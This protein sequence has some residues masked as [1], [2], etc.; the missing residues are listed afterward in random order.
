MVWNVNLRRG[1]SI[2][3][4]GVGGIALEHTARRRLVEDGRGLESLGHRSCRP[5][6]HACR[7]SKVGFKRCHLRSSP[8]RQ[9]LDNGPLSPWRPSPPGSTT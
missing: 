7:C 8:R 2:E 6:L 3:V 9:Y 4:I 5:Q 1:R